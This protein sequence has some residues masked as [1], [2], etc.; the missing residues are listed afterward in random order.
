MT[1]Q[2]VLNDANTLLQQENFDPLQNDAEI[3]LADVLGVKREFL[4][5]NPQHEITAD[6]QELFF[7]YIHTRLKYVPV[8]QITGHKEFYG[9]DFIINKEV[10]IPRPETEIL[11]EEA[12]KV[13]NSFPNL[14]NVADIGTGSGCIAISLLAHSN[15][16]YRVYATDISKTA[17]KVAK[18]NADRHE[19]LV[20]DR[21]VFLKG[22]LLKALGMIPVEVLVANLP[23]LTPEEYTNTKELSYEPRLAFVSNKAGLGLFEEMFLQLQTRYQTPYYILL[24]I[25]YNQAGDIIEIADKYLEIRS[26]EI[27]KDIAGK[28]RVI[29]IRLGE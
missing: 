1:I 11:V 24:E 6:Q 29:K 19:N 25:G 17:L 3:L 18:V 22:N 8:A 7:D 16:I 2:R 13:I 9:I 14:I 5:I 26:T 23:Y 12:L 28:D 15:N 4:H 20:R 21:I 10:L 27:I